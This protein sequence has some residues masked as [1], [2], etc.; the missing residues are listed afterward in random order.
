LLRFF[1]RSLFDLQTLFVKQ[2]LV[3]KRSLITLE[4]PYVIYTVFTSV[5][6]KNWRSTE[7]K[8]KIKP[9]VLLGFVQSTKLCV[10]FE[11]TLRSSNS[12]FKSEAFK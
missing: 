9:T 4:K 10:N 12:K 1:K 7:K 3:I 5:A 6:Y 8:S 2:T 11:F